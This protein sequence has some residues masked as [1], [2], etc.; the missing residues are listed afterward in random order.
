MSYRLTGHNVFRLGT[1]MAIY[2][3]ITFISLFYSLKLNC[4]YRYYFN[5]SIK[6]IWEKNNSFVVG[7]EE[8]YN[9][10]NNKHSTLLKNI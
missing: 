8:W 4:S 7:F 1:Y 2:I 6:S 10:L 5:K 9:I 3:C